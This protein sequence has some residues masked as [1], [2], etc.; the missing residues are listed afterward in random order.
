LS[1]GVKLTPTARRIANACRENAERAI[2]YAADAADI[3]DYEDA[4][5]LKAEAIVYDDLAD[6]IERG[7]FNS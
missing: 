4:A 2:E 5:F 7:E 3:G 1:A 6:M